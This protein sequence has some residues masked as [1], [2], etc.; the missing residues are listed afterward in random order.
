MRIARFDANW[1][2]RAGYPRNT[3][4]S[5]F[6]TSSKAPSPFFFLH[7]RPGIQTPLFSFQVLSN[8]TDGGFFR[9]ISLNLEGGVNRDHSPLRGATHITPFNREPLLITYEAQSGRLAVVQRRPADYFTL[10]Q[11]F[12]DAQG[13]ATA[14][15]D[16]ELPEDCFLPLVVQGELQCQRIRPRPEGECEIRIE[17]FAHSDEGWNLRNAGVLPST[18]RDLNC[19]RL[20][21]LRTNQM[22]LG[23][24]LVYVLQRPDRFGLNQLH[25][26]FVP[27]VGEGP[28]RV[29]H[30]LDLEGTSSVTTSWVHAGDRLAIAM[31]QRVGSGL[32]EVHVVVLNPDGTRHIEPLRTHR[33]EDRNQVLHVAATPSRLGVLLSNGGVTSPGRWHHYR[34]VD[35][36][37]GELGELQDL[38]VDESVARSL[39]PDIRTAG[40]HLVLAV[41]HVLQSGSRELSVFISS[42]GEPLL[43]SWAPELDGHTDLEM[44]TA[45][46]D[47][48]VF[49]R[50]DRQGIDVLATDPQGHPVTQ[51]RLPYEFLDVPTLEVVHTGEE[52][53]F[54]ILPSTHGEGRIFATT[55]TCE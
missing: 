27:P 25:L 19:T 48:L 18:P 53:R 23:E 38:S 21:S 55:G 26:V 8:E 12:V 44:V 32:R 41:H 47:H 13:E 40:E 16:L 45:A 24:E 43:D 31:S 4:V 35:L 11:Y 15:V 14:P 5:G 42:P 37:S 10:E 1:Q 3:G 7:E 17:V 6:P 33:V 49:A 9:F 54:L 30:L 28:V 22:L 46:P 52:L 2:M 36:I 20:G 50:V 51:Y 39:L 29:E 34:E